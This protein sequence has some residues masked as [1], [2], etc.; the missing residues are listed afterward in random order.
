MGT[1]TTP[2][3][4]EIY[5]KDWGS[6]QPLVFSH[7]WPLSADDWDTQLMFFL[8]HGFRVIAAD[9]RGHGRSTQTDAGHDMDHYDDDLAAVIAH[10]DVSDAVHIGHS[11]G[12][13]D[14]T[15]PPVLTNASYKLQSRN[16]AV[17]EIV[18]VPDRGH[19]LTIDHG[20]REVA[21][22]AR[23]FIRRFV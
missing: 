6:G 12:A 22:I 8:G 14:H 18:E 7:G 20:W 3:G 21:E 11:T 23:A 16:D 19:A 5:Y 4:V 2:D 13:R 10:L 1:I 17:T 15:V 9:R